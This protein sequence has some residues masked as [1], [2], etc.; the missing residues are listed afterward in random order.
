[1]EKIDFS[2]IIIGYNIEKYLNRCLKSV[3]GQT[4]DNFE[5]IFVNDGS[6]DNTIGVAKEFTVL[7]SNYIIIDKENGG[8]ISARKAGLNVA[9]GDYIVFVDGD[10]S[11]KEDMLFSFAKYAFGPVKYDIII[12]DLYEEKNNNWEYKKNDLMYGDVD[13]ELYFK[14]IMD[15][16]V[17]HYMCSKIFLRSFLID[18]GYMDFPDVTIAEDLYSNSIFSVRQPRILYIDYAG[19]NYHNNSSSLTREGKISLIDKQLLTLDELK[20]FFS[21]NFGSKYDYYVIYQWYL[22]AFGYIQTRYSYSFKRYLIDKCIPY[23]SGI[24]NN[25]LYKNQKKDLSR[26]YGRLLLFLYIRIPFAARLIDPLSKRVIDL[27]HINY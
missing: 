11:I 24:T 4:Y 13:S 26:F 10:D 22:F 20:K 12:S 18:S 2:I 7:K 23:M 1:M 14:G 16:S 9:K 15:G 8:I 19:Y 6:V 5:V 3:F 21:N 17:Y 25:P 27:L